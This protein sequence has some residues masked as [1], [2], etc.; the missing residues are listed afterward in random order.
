MVKD[1]DYCL[2]GKEYET[3]QQMY[4]IGDNGNLGNVFVWIQP[5]PGHYFEVPE[6]QIKALPQRVLISQPHCAFLPHCSI[7][8]PSYYKDGKLEKTGQKFVVENDAMV[9]H[10]S[11]VSG[12]AD[13]PGE[14]RLLGA[15]KEMEVTLVPS[16]NYVSIRCNIHPWMS[17]YLRVFDH[18]YAA[19]SSVG[20]DPGKKVY[21]DLKDP[22]FGTYEIKGVPVG[23]KVRL[24]AWH[25]S[26]S[27][28]EKGWLTSPKGDEVTIQKGPNT[29]DFKAELK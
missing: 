11:N 22:K 27:V 14:N 25:E 24:F 15:G 29:K 5:E 9:G 18:P 26:D 12:G 17:A 23:A 10:N 28:G 21:E 1:R 6:D 19:V 20:G 13:N 2:A 3:N 7:H 16:R 8:V 4:R